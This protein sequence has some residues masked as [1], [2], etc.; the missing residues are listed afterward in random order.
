[1]QVSRR[2]CSPYNSGLV[3]VL[4]ASSYKTARALLRPAHD[5]QWS[6]IGFVYG[7]GTASHL[8]RNRAIW[9]PSA[10]F[11][12]DVWLW[13]VCLCAAWSWT[14]VVQG[15]RYVVSV[16]R[17]AQLHSSCIRCR[18]SLY[19]LLIRLWI[20]EACMRSQRWR[21]KDLWFMKTIASLRKQEPISIFFRIFYARSI[22]SWLYINYSEITQAR[23]E[24]ENRW[25]YCIIYQLWSQL[26]KP[27]DSTV[28][29]RRVFS[30]S[31]CLI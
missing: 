18:K 17:N 19:N 2:S 31:E 21:F 7:A 11:S 12:I 1:M 23:S 27:W 25:N 28:S 10:Q 30:T 13:A 24:I 14:L 26:L 8:L 29:V 5:H 9:S 15:W 6:R 4:F 22:S 20:S 3:Y 16:G